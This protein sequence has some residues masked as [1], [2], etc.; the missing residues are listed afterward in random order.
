MTELLTGKNAIVTGGAGGIGLAI[1]QA[2]V[3][4]G[5]NLVVAD[6]DA[7]RAAEAAAELS[8][9]AP[10]AA[11]ITSI[12]TDVSDEQSMNDLVTGAVDALGGLDIMV[13]NA[14]IT[15]DATMRRMS[16]EDFDKVIAVHLRGAWL[17]TRA[18]SLV[19]REKKS[20][21]II[22]IASTS[23]KQGMAG[24]TNYSSAKAGM[25]GLTKAAAKEVGWAGVRVNAVLPGLVRSPM[26]ENMREDVWEQKVKETPLGRVGEPSEV[27]GPVVFLS[28]DLASYVT[29]VALLASGGRAM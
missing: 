26:T 5:A 27:A 24:Q 19:M 14:G 8:R 9:T 20:G 2:L 7:D 25:I 12:A 21:S 18:A 17:G 15:R 4:H 23:G 6:I 29:G 11:T 28:S 16:A 13:N 1:G 22:N 3:E 10:S